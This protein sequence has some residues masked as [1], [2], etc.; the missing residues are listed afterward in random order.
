MLKHDGN[1]LFTN[2][3]VSLPVTVLQSVPFDY[4]RLNLYPFSES[5][6]SEMK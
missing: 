1:P 4:S 5:I 3:T 2:E 6:S